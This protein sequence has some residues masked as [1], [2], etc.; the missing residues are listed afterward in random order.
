MRKTTPTIVGFEDKNEDKESSHEES[1]EV[2]MALSWYPAGKR[3][4]SPTPSLE[5]C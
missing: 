4:L 2:G 5:S 1:L 3:R